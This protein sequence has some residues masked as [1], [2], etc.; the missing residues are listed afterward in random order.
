MFE[1]RRRP[2][3][4]AG[5]GDRQTTQLGGRKKTARKLAPVE[6][7][8]TAAALERS[9]LWHLGRRAMT[10]HE[11]RLALQK[12]AKRAEAVHGENPLASTWIEALV[13]RLRSSLLLDDNRVATARAASGRARGLSSRRI[14]M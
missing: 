8:L 13:E 14:E 11:L 1:Q 6:K 3:G 4:E 10:E 2:G 9:A 5:R 7:P 12:K